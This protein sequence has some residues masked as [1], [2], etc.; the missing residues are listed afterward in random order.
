MK[1][2]QHLPAR[3]SAWKLLRPFEQQNPNINWSY[4][5]TNVHSRQVKEL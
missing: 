5:N 3:I 1:I 2:R 4:E